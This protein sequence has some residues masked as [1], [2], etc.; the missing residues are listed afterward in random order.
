[1]SHHSAGSTLDSS[2]SFQVSAETA[3]RAFNSRVRKRSN[4][5]SV[6]AIQDIT[7]G[8]Y[9]KV[10]VGVLSQSRRVVPLTRAN[11]GGS[12]FQDPI[13][14]SDPWE[15]NIQIDE[16]Y[17]NSTKSCHVEGSEKKIECFSCEGRGMK[18]C[19]RCQGN[20]WTTCGNCDGQ[21]QV[22]CRWCNGQGAVL[23]P[24]CRGVNSVV[25]TSSAKSKGVVGRA[26]VGG[27]VAGPV[28]AV[29]GG[30]TA[31]TQTVTTSKVCTTCFGKGSVM[32]QGCFG[33][34]RITCT[35]CRGQGKLTCQ[36][37]DG[38]QK[39][40]C[41]VCGA[42]G[43]LIEYQEVEV[44]N[45]FLE[46]TTEINPFQTDIARRRSPAS[47]YE[48]E[49]HPADL[50]LEELDGFP[51][52]E[53]SLVKPAIDSALLSGPGHF[54]KAKV[55]ISS[56]PVFVATYDSRNK[57][58]HFMLVG[59]DLAIEKTSIDKV[60]DFPLFPTRLY[61]WWSGISFLKK[62]VIGATTIVVLALVVFLL[63]R[64]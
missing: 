48:I 43:E 23:C 40:V 42:S 32:C 57:K 24:K 55:S 62:S 16:T 1:M 15:L 5:I 51:E 21:G 45:I 7:K 8:T 39:L 2:S 19:P 29:L 38:H 37:C 3:A 22:K 13:R 52:T 33:A 64:L 27:L 26:V 11:E 17:G 6:A 9:F 54:L 47:S 30:A 49:L 53:F 14:L 4:K 18:D 28:G 61:D 56:I 58:K 44:Q 60:L 25:E 10:A 31:R 35:S 34:G 46:K 12:H 50:P 41:Q 36:T 59:R 63:S 20:G